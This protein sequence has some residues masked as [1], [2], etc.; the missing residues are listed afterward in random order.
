MTPEEVGFAGAAQIQPAVLARARL[1]TP[2]E[3]NAF[4]DYQREPCAA[5]RPWNARRKTRLLDDRIS[6]VLPAR[7]HTRPRREPGSPW[8]CRAHP[9][10]VSPTRR[11]LRRVCVPDITSVFD[12]QRCRPLVVGIPCAWLRTARGREKNCRKS[13]GDF[14]DHLTACAFAMVTATTPSAW[15]PN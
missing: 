12:H 7:R 11:G 13:T 6:A 14:Q 3:G 10:H 9:R 5:R 1:P 4:P 2:D 15:L 8:R